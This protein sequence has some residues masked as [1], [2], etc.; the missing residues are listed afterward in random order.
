MSYKRAP[1]QRLRGGIPWDMH[2]RAYE[3]YC[4][5][6]GKQ[7]ALIEGGCRGG[8]G[9]GELDMLILGWRDELERRD[10]VKLVRDPR[11]PPRGEEHLMPERR[12]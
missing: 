4:K 7:Q 9:I 3:A 11:Y 2:M 8:F 12:P 6:Y 1:T 5:L 10:G